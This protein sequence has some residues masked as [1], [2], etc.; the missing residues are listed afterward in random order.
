ML[1]ESDKKCVKMYKSSSKHILVAFLL[2]I[3]K[4]NGADLVD[5][6]KS[7]SDNDFAA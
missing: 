3:W 2:V 1:P 4:I 6:A 7:A 5:L